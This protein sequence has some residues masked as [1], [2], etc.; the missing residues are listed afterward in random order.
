MFNVMT[1]MKNTTKQKLFYKKESE[2]TRKQKVCR[3]IACYGVTIFAAL[4]GF[5]LVDA[6]ASLLEAEADAAENSIVIAQH[7]N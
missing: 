7:L 3:D 4:M 5:L 6:N 2:R 1:E